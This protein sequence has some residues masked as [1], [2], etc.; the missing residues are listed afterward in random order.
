LQEAFLSP[1]AKLVSSER[2]LVKD[3][4]AKDKARDFVLKD[5]SH[6]CDIFHKICYGIL[7]AERLSPGGLSSDTLESNLIPDLIHK[8]EESGLAALA[9]AN[10]MVL[11]AAARYR[12]PTYELDR[13]YGIMQ[14]FKLRLGHSAP[15]ADPNITLTLAQLETELGVDLL[16]QHPIMCQLHVIT[17]SPGTVVGQAWHVQ[18]TSVAPQLLNRIPYPFHNYY[19][20]R[21]KLKVSVREHESQTWGYFTGKVCAFEG[22]HEAWG[23]AEEEQSFG[24]GENA[25]SI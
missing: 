22:L 4:S 9:R 21:S 24:S 15:G 23:N 3:N 10:P 18:S 6:A 20:S 25:K 8:T 17:E 13:V 11:Y 5:L 12:N 19:T 1:E 14:I 16:R 7:A 2:K